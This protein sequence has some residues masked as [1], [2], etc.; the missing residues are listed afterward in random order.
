MRALVFRGFNR[1]LSLECIPDPTPGPGEVVLKVHRCGICGTDLHRTE[2]NIFSLKP[3]AVPGHE[4]AGE[5]VALGSGV[6]TLRVGD[7][8]TALPYLGCNACMACLSGAPNFCTQMRNVGSDEMTGG[9]AEYVAV[10]APWCVKLPQALSMEDG[11]LVEPLAVGLHAIV[12]AGLKAGDRVAVIGAGPIGLAAIWWARRAGAGRIVATATSDR[13]AALARDMG[14]DTFLAAAPGE[15]PANAVVEAL[16]G[17]ADIVFECVGLPGLL[18]QAIACAKVRG[19]VAVLGVCV[20]RDPYLP[21]LAM[22]KE[23]DVRFSVVYDLREFQH[24]V[25]ALDRGDVAPRAMIT[26]RA[27]LDEAPDAFEA[28]RSRTRQ[29]KVMISPWS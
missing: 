5:V 13:R 2:S 20:T 19:V 27:N 12:R 3:G 28:L 10:G 24:C 22:A 21:L 15:S 4:F 18:D 16:G 7:R 25:D 17:G 23:V 8:V 9:Y 29:C 6:S 14:A 26:D 1:K 11:A